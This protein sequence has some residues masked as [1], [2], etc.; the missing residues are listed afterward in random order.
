M[1]KPAFQITEDYENFNTY[2]LALVAPYVK[3]LLLSDTGLED[4]LANLETIQEDILNSIRILETNLIVYNDDAKEFM[5]KT[6]EANEKFRLEI[7]E[8]NEKFRLEIKEDNEKFRLEVK[9]FMNKTD[10]ANEKF[11][12]EVIGFMNKT[13]EANEKF[14]LEIRE[15]NEKFRL[16][17]REEFTSFREEVNEKFEKIDQRF[18]KIDQ[19][20]EA[21]NHK[22]IDLHK[23]I[24]RMTVFFI[25]GLGTIVLLAKL[26]DKIWP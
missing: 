9:E 24:N 23:A 10:E 2:I 20:F 17:I 18:E 7:K 19:R 13:D 21:M 5:E 16:E 14:R 8:D 15:E 12:L 11:R 4:R 6:D 22:F 3:Q 26:I 1:P 25:G